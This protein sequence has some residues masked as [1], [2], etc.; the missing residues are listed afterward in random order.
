MGNRGY[1]RA[2]GT[3][4]YVTIAAAFLVIAV[5]LAM[6]L[7]FKISDIT[8]EGASRY[9]G[10]QIVE[11][12]G[13]EL[14]D[15]IFFV[16]TGSAEI[17]IKD[18]LPYIDSVSVTRDL[19][20]RVVIK[21]TESIPA[22]TVQNGG[23]VLLLD[24]DLRILDEIV[25]VPAGTVEIRGVTP[26]EPKPGSDLDLGE[27]E[28]ARLSSLREFMVALR[29]NGVIGSVKWLDVSNLSSV[30]FDYNGYTVNFG[31]VEDLARKFQLLDHFTK[32]NP[33]AGSGQNVIYDEGQG[34]RLLYTA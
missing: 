15:S 2:G 29:D 4:L 28:S 14:D 32:Q 20:G 17:H 26:V 10:G 23:S 22:A 31:R 25:A 3:A 1:R 18:A 34:G 8:V 5:I 11:A 27:N 16:S 9:T 33:Q 6:A 7:F 12:S 21:V 24:A 30:V 13:I 19:P